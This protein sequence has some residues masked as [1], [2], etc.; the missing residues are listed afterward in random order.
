MGAWW[1]SGTR[2]GYAELM[3]SLTRSTLLVAF[4]LAL[5]GCTTRLAPDPGELGGSE[6]VMFGHIAARLT[7]PTTR[8]YPPEIRF[9]ELV[10]RESGERFRVDVHGADSPLVLVIP[11]G[12]YEMNRIMINEGAFQAMANPGPKFRVAADSVTYIGTWTFGIAAPTY[13]RKIALTVTDE[14][15]EAKAFLFSRYETL[16]NRPITTELPTP[17]SSVTR[18]YETDPYPLIWWFRRHHTT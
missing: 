7:A 5:W 15:G 10:H 8:A 16:S 13:D 6:T 4:C 2:T 14:L 18:L 17:P 3:R 1:N 12:T 9:F 11:A